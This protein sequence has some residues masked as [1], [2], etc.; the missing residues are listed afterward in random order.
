MKTPIFRQS[1]RTADGGWEKSP[2]KPM[3]YSTYAFYLNR[4]GEL[5]GVEGK[6]TAYCLRRGLANALLSVA[7]DPIVDQVMRHDPMTGCLANAYLNNR[8]GFNTQDAYLG[9]DPSA[10]G[11]TK[12]FS[13]MSIRFS[14]APKI[15]KE[16]LDKLPRGDQIENL[17]REKQQ[18]RDEL[19]RKYKFI[20]SAPEDERTE[21]KKKCDELRSKEKTFREEMTKLFQ[22]GYRR[23][24]E[25]EILEISLKGLATEE[26]AEPA[27]AHQLLERSSLIPI[28]CDFNKSLSV[29]MTTDR[30]IQ[31][32]NGFVRLAACREVRLPR[33]N[34]AE[35]NDESSAEDTHSTLAPTTGPSE[36]IP[37]VIDKTQCIC[38]VGDSRLSYPIR[39]RRFKRVANMM[40]HFE[41]VHLR[42]KKDKARFVCNHPK[43]QHLGDFLTSLDHFKNHVQTVHGVKLRA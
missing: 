21:Y 20:K 28:L 41:N 26:K 25:N 2:T 10:D 42:H 29:E 1:V 4:I 13:H 40:N 27:V 24:I 30:K 38:C 3:K 19:C 17:R 23:K 31:A 8:V 16:E 12:A 35:E 7:P 43:C 34:M 9:T 33:T 6:L 15:S 39:M 36:D 5:L 32:I 37:L 18:I 11:L 22:A 14:P